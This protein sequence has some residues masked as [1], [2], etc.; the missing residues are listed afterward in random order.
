MRLSFIVCALLYACSPGE[1]KVGKSWLVEADGTAPAPAGTPIEVGVTAIP[2][3]LSG[4]VPVA[5]D[6]DVP[7]PD[8]LAALQAVEKAG[9]VP[10][11][12]VAVRTHIEALVAPQRQTGDAIRLQARAEGKACVSPPDNPEATCVSRLDQKHIDRSFVRQI[13]YKA[14]TEYGL[15]RIRVEIDPSL[16]WADAV[17]AIDGARTCCGEDA[18]LEVSVEPG[19]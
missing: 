18:G 10:A 2:A 14:V 19:W 17:R 1:P 8:A 13:L 16:T 11:P 15:K 4:A 3:K 12:L 7:Y 6:R 9:G 5:I